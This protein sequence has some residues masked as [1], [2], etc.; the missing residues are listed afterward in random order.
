MYEVN[1]TALKSAAEH[2]QNILKDLKTQIE[3]LESIEKTMMN[4]NVW[5]GPARSEYVANFRKYEAALAEL[6]NS[7]VTHLQAL[8]EEMEIY[9]RPER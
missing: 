7:A 2:L 3:E 1:F 5:K 9:L 8:Q 4:E 6:Y